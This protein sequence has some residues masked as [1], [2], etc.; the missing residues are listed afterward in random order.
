VRDPQTPAGAEYRVQRTGHSRRRTF[1]DHLLA[2][3]GMHIGLAV[4][5]HDETE[6]AKFFMYGFLENSVGP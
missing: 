5:D 2:G 3:I 6:A 1:T 4:R